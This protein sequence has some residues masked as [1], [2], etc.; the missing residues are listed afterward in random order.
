MKD[1]GSVSHC[2]GIKF[3]QDTNDY[4]EVLTQRQYTEAVLKRFDMQDCKP[5]K[6]PIDIQQIYN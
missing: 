2:L 4:S 3:Q 1:L 6:T 5:V